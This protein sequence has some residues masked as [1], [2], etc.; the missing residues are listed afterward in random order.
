MQSRRKRAH[1]RATMQRARWSSV[2][3][4]TRRAKPVS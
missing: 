2:P 3:S 4:M 1:T